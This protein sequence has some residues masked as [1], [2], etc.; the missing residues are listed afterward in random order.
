MLVKESA[1][2]VPFKKNKIVMGIIFDW[3]ITRN[4]VETIDTPK[5][6]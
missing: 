5:R 1:T 6:I 2:K 4:D 3:P